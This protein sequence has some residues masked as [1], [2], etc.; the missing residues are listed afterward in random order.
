MIFLPYCASS[1]SFVNSFLRTKGSEY[2]SRTRRH[3]QFSEDTVGC[4][5]PDSPR[6]FCPLGRC[7]T[8]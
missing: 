1:L 2:Y 5:G 6:R 4:A 7:Q 3:Q 8:H